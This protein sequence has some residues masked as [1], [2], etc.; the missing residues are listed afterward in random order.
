MKQILEDAL[1][2]RTPL[3]VIFRL[4]DISEV[5]KR[6]AT[7]CVRNLSGSQYTWLTAHADGELQSTRTQASNV[8][9]ISGEG[10]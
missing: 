1:D 5:D 6:D 2:I 4:S 7:R 8:V 3:R 9:L 10:V